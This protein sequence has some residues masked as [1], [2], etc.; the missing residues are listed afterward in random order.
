MYGIIKNIIHIVIVHKMTYNFN[1]HQ[2]SLSDIFTFLLRCFIKM[3]SLLEVN[4]IKNLKFFINSFYFILIQLK[5]FQ[6]FFQSIH[7]K[8][9]NKLSEIISLLLRDCT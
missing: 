2:E 7:P 8:C 1:V 9:R 6:V 4:T 3:Y 5:N